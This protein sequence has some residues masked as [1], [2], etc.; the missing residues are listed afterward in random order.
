MRLSQILNNLLSNAVKFT[1]K[2]FV[3]IS[4]L[5]LL[6]LNENEIKVRFEI[7]DTGIGIPFEKQQSIFQMFSQANSDTTRKFGGTGLGLTITKKLLQLFN[8][9]IKLTSELNKGTTFYFDIIFRKAS[10]QNTVMASHNLNDGKSKSKFKNILLVEDNEVNRQVTAKFLV[11]WRLNVDTANDG[12]EAIKKIEQYN[13]DLILMDIH[14]PEMNGI[15]ACKIIRNHADEKIKTTPII[16]LTAA[17]MDNEKTAL[18]QLGMND[19]ISKPFN[20]SDLYNKIYQHIRQ[21]E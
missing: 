3:E 8:S 13:Y 11:K 10:A 4:V 5:K 6:H 1:D 2:G 15:E 16:A 19:Y 17:T 12:L 7:S 20:P 9:E 14:M 21:D 18:I